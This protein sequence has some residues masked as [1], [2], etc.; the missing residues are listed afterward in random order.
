MEN[1]IALFSKRV[2]DSMGDVPLA[3]PMGPSVADIA[4]PLEA[5]QASSATVPDAEGRPAG[6]VAERDLTRRDALSGIHPCCRFLAVPG[7]DKSQYP[8]P[9]YSASRSIAETP[10]RRSAAEL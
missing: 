4:R 3:V 1:R 7:G 8:S 9:R 5:E 2:R 6:I 10:A